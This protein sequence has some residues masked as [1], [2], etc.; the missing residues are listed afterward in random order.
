MIS[1]ICGLHYYLGSNYL[2][3]LTNVQPQQKY[4]FVKYCLIRMVVPG[5]KLFIHRNHPFPYMLISVWLLICGL[6]SLPLQPFQEINYHPH[7]PKLGRLDTRSESLLHDL[8]S[9]N[10]VAASKMLESTDAGLRHQ[11]KR[12]LKAN[13]QQFKYPPSM[14]KLGE[15]YRSGNDEPHAFE[16]TKHAAR[17]GD[18]DAMH[19]LGEMYHSHAHGLLGSVQDYIASFWYYSAATAGKAES[20]ERLAG[21]SDHGIILARVLAK[22]IAN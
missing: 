8:V 3:I 14:R 5:L 16:W 13:S 22:S 17:N 9:A 19:N 15:I 4:T 2:L 20:A 12:I 21:L 11:A 18:V 1:L 6:L 7:L 10:H